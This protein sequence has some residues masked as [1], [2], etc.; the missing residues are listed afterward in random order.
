VLRLD[1]DFYVALTQASKNRVFGL[2]INTTRQA[3]LNYASFFVH[4]NVSTEAV[5][6]H[7]RA[8]IKALAKRDGDGAARIADTYLGRGAEHL[9]ASGPVA[10]E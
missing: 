8:L 2:L 10:R 3:V 6:R 9:L 7:H 1:F 5:R 4:F